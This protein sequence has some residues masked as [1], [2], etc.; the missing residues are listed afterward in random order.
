MIGLRASANVAVLALGAALQ[1]A[2]CGAVDE[3]AAA[4]P[5][6]RLV[7]FSDHGLT[8]ALPPQWRPAHERLTPGLSEPREVLVVATFE[9]R[10]RRT[11]CAHVAGQRA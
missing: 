4:P 11:A 6:T 5:T 3:P 1:G 7:R 2:G 9:P 8:V 10:Y